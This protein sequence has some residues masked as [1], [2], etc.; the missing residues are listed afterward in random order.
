MIKLAHLKGSAASLLPHR[1]LTD[2]HCLCC[3]AGLA[4][5]LKNTLSVPQI[6]GSKSLWDSGCQFLSV[7]FYVVQTSYVCTCCESVCASRQVWFSPASFG[8]MEVLFGASSL[9]LTAARGPLLWSKCC[10]LWGEITGASGPVYRTP[11]SVSLIFHLLISRWCTRQSLFFS[12]WN[13][14]TPF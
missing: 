10:T 8:W 12:F 4:I 11:F 1:P 9:K 13:P 14:G 5:S 7:C 6:K 3:G 2:L